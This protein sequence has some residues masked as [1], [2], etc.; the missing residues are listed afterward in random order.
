MTFRYLSL[1]Y[2]APTNAHLWHGDPAGKPS[3][4]HVNEPGILQSVA[5][6]GET[7]SR[8][9]GMCPHLQAREAEVAVPQHAI[10]CG[11]LQSQKRKKDA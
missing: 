10:R 7:L 9:H 3:S 5:A 2:C 1:C 6:H 8:K 4:L 11:T